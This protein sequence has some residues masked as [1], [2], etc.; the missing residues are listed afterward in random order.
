ML[1]IIVGVAVGFGSFILIY[2]SVYII[3]EYRKPKN[4]FQEEAT[5]ED[6]LIKKEFPRPKEDLTKKEEIQKEV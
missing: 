6:R 4:I 2:G 1:P 5:A 3:T